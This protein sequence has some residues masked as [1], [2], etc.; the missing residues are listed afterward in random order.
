MQVHNMMESLV[1]DC[2]KDLLSRQ[3]EIAGQLNDSARSDVLAIA[4]N[5][6][7][8]RYVTTES[9]EMYTKTQLRAHYEPDVYRELSLAIDKVLKPRA[10][11][12]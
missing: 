5:N 7:P 2:L 9:G 10:K 6:L 12:F 3:Q 1:K 4:L 8:A 11:D